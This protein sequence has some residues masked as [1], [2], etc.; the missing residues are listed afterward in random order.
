MGPSVGTG[1]S[2]APCRHVARRSL[3]CPA[4]SSL[5]STPNS[6]KLLEIVGYPAGSYRV[7][8]SDC[9]LLTCEQVLPKAVVVEVNKTTTL[10][11]DIDT[12]IR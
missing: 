9:V 7:D 6:V 4:P 3:R 8:L 5:W 12:G 11:I 2:M 1:R 10:A